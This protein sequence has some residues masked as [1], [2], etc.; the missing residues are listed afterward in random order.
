MSIAIALLLPAF[1]ASMS[2]G[3]AIFVGIIWCD[4]VAAVLTK[5]VFGGADAPWSMLLGFNLVYAVVAVLVFA[6]FA[7]DPLQAKRAVRA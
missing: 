7:A 2:I 4:V 5:F 3:W 1:F 6:A